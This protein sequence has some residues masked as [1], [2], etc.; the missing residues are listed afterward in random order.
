MKKITNFFIV[1]VFIIFSL[2]TSFAW[3]FDYKSTL[4][5]DEQIALKKQANVI[6][7]KINDKLIKID[8]D[9]Q[10]VLIK[11]LNKK[12]DSIVSK[13]VTEN[14]KFLFMYLEFLLNEKVTLIEN[15]NST[16]QELPIEA[17]CS[18]K[19]WSWT[20]KITLLNWKVINTSDCTVKSCDKWY[21]IDKNE[22]I[23]ETTTKIEEN[24]VKDVFTTEKR[25]CFINNW[26]WEENLTFYNWKLSIKSDCIFVSCNTGYNFKYW[27]CEKVESS[28]QNVLNSTWAT[29]TWTT[30][31]W[32]DTPDII[33]WKY[34][35]S[36]CNVWSTKAGIWSESFWKFFQWWRNKWL[37][38]NEVISSY[39]RQLSTIDWSIWLNATTDNY[40]FVCD[41]SLKSPY[42]WANTDISDNW[43]WISN[44]N[45]YDSWWWITNINILK[46]WPCSD[47]YHVPSQSEWSWLIKEWWNNII[48]IIKNKLKLPIAGYIGWDDC[49][50]TYANNWYYWSSTPYLDKAY[51]LWFYNGWVGAEDVNNRAIAMPVRCFKN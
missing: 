33:I 17:I 14:N 23:L 40:W 32:C 15:N 28:I 20:Q 27:V 6:Y 13:K 45:S 25:D 2:H 24:L 51:D 41:F 38:M 7:N 30:Y 12:I 10:L 16:N 44:T 49:T 8:K 35:I 11:L 39:N 26:V 31:P 5:E 34:T 3:D 42:T 43:W 18:I 29:L 37:D 47:W 9:K 21:K 4:K 22:C 46:Q 36:A 1:L 50:R 48:D 19:N